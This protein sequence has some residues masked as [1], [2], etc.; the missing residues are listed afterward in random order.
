MKNE[1]LSEM[2]RAMTKILIHTWMI[3]IRSRVKYAVRVLLVSCPAW[4]G[5]AS[6]N[7]NQILHR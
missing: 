6:D 1:E 2:N 7:F 3:I 4:A 5:Q